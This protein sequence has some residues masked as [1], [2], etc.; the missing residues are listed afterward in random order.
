MGRALRLLGLF[1]TLLFTLTNLSACAGCSAHPARLTQEIDAPSSLTPD[2]LV[3]PDAPRLL[4]ALRQWRDYG[5]PR[6]VAATDHFDDRLEQL[7]ANLLGGDCVAATFDHVVTGTGQA[8]CFDITTSTMDV[9]DAA[10]KHV[11]V[12]DDGPRHDLPE[13]RVPQEPPRAEAARDPQS[14][15]AAKSEGQPS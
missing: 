3:D 4:S 5:G 11:A 14:L 6:I 15:F 2:A 13:L 10:C 9:S 7:L 1:A 12:A 8:S